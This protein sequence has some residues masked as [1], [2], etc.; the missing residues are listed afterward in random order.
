MAPLVDACLACTK[1]G[2]GVAAP[3]KPAV[4]VQPVIPALK[5]WR[6]EDQTFKVIFKA[7]LEMCETLS[8]TKG[9]NGH[10]LQS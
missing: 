5:R 8:F 2:V 4:V 3:H 9:R 1:P 7:S 10:P 6:Q